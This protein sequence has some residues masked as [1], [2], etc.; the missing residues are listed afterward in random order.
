MKR[1]KNQARQGR[2]FST[3]LETS[4]RR[5][6][7]VSFRIASARAVRWPQ[8]GLGERRAGHFTLAAFLALAAVRAGLG[9]AVATAH[10]LGGAFGA[11]G[12]VV[13]LVRARGLDDRHDAGASWWWSRPA[14]TTGL[15]AQAVRA[16]AARVSRMPLV[17]LAE[18]HNP[19]VALD[20]YLLTA[21]E[22]EIDR[23][24]SW[25]ADPA[26]LVE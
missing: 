9:E 15:V 1:A 20:E 19:L 10:R 11:G 24:D 16:P 12:G 25:R 8:S 17:L 21:D 26:A 6:K 14:A 7:L 5:L 13:D 23:T 4:G 2:L 3:E 22:S 18:S